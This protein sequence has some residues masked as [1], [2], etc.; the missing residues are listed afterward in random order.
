M[1]R[2]NAVL[3]AV[4]L[5][6][7]CAIA[8]NTLVVIPPIPTGITFRVTVGGPMPP[9]SHVSVTSGPAPVKF[10]YKGVRSPFSSAPPPPNYMAVFPSEGTTP[11]NLLI[12]LNE[13]VVRGMGPGNYVLGV[14]FSTVDQS[15]ESEAQVV[16]V[17]TLS[18]PRGPAI[19]SVVND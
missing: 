8:Q 6:T 17:L 11:T 9:A 1:R 7:G 4:S 5:T 14:V 3:F 10:K 18:A 15:P 16:V 12:G 2:I 13:G 19:T